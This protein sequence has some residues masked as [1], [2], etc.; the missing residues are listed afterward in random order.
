MEGGEPILTIGELK[1]R[2]DAVT[3][4]GAG[5]KPSPADP[6]DPPAPATLPADPA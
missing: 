2:L 5:A 6:A 3:Q 4:V 1:I